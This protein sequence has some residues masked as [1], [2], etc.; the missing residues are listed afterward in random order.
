MTSRTALSGY[1]QAFLAPLVMIGA[2]CRFSDFT[3]TSRCSQIPLSDYLPVYFEACKGATAVKTGVYQL[4]FSMILMPF[5]II[6]GLSVKKT[7]QYRPQLWVA[8]VFV[9]IGVGLLT[10][11]KEDS[12]LGWAIGF[13]A[14][15]SPGIGVLMTTTY[16]PV[17]APG[18]PFSFLNVSATF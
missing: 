1:L 16:F 17:L 4:T 11:L 18:T 7:Q 5:G 2:D 8:W 14:V 15:F 9:I 13:M 6:S 3:V 10:M 12:P